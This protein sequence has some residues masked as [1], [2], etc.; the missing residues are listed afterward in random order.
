M[1]IMR[2]GPFRDLT[3]IQEE[4]NK[5]F[6]DI[7]RRTTMPAEGR[8]LSPAIDL[9]ETDDEYRVKVDLP[10]ISKDDMSISIVGNSIVIKGEK[11]QEKKEEKENY[12]YIERSYG[13]F[14]RVIDLPVDIDAD[15]ILAE[16]ENGVLDIKVPKSEK[17][18]P[19]E[20]EVKVSESK[21]EKK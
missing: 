19:R 7:F 9:S 16:F 17:V 3:S 2:R 8:I 6:D 21:K 15:K 12:H 10:G 14:K 11:K 4:M 18:K 1:V 13:S 20:I 5:L